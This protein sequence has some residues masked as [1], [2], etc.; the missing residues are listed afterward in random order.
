MPFERG[1]PPA[2]VV[3]IQHSPQD[4]FTVMTRLPEYAVVCSGNKSTKL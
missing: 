1:Q 4:G 2:W 3:K